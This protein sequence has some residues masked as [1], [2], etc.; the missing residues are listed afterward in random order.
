MP[1]HTLPEAAKAY[2][3]RDFDLKGLAGISDAQDRI[4]VSPPGLDRPPDCRVGPRG[5]GLG[6]VRRE[7]LGG[8]P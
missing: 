7:V 4:F 2:R 5:G 1:A 8:A 6:R 3:K